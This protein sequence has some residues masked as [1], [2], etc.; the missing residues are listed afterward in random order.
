MTM[1][2]INQGTLPLDRE[3]NTAP[4]NS[5]TGIPTAQPRS[6]VEFL[7]ITKGPMS[8]AEMRENGNNKSFICENRDCST[9][10]IQLKKL[11]FN[12]LL[13]LVLACQ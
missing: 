3:Q 10:L 6:T 5:R 7:L 8:S 1:I 4:L 12:I 11:V 9:E 13:L 2:H